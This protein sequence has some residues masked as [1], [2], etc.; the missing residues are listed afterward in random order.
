MTDAA[1]GV[2]QLSRSTRLQ[3]LNAEG[4]FV[5]SGFADLQQLLLRC[6]GAPL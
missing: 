3:E 5:T 4:T 1:A 6:S 2:V